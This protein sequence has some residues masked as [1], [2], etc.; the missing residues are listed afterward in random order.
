MSQVTPQNPILSGFNKNST[1][2]EVLDGIDLTGKTVIVTG[3]YSGIGLETTRALANKGAIVIVPAR[4]LDK[5]REALEGIPS[6]EIAELDLMNPESIDTFAKRFLSSERKLDILINN[7]GIM[8]PPLTRDARGYESQFATNHLGHFQLTARLWP[9]LNKAGS[10][11]VV[12]LSS[13]GHMYGGV[14]FDDPNFERREYNKGLAYAQSK[15]ANA[16]FAVALDKLGYD[17]NIRAF[18][19][20]PGAI[21]TDLLRYVSEEEI[22]GSVITEFK[23]EEQGAA[24][25]VWCATSPLL[26]GK[27]GVYCL[28]ADIAKAASSMDEMPDAVF[29]H[30][31][32]PSLAERLWLLSED[33]IGVRFGK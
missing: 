26:E 1:A 12:S 10:A 27:G 28:D 29:H 25:S 23:T 2:A 3:G 11:R 21:K 32:D 33:L 15:S 24:T 19:V 17:Y 31:I 13:A 9:A 30:A 14:D 6:V 5:A 20:H 4:N 7:A 16:L 8:T 18:S 22:S